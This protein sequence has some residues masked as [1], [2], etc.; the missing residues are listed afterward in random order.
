MIILKYTWIGMLAIVYI[1]LLCYSIKD[2]IWTKKIFYRHW[3]KYLEDATYG[4]IIAHILVLFGFSLI[5]YFRR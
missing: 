4:F 1:V 3:Y 5:Y 2:I